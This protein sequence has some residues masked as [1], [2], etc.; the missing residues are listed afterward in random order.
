[1]FIVSIPLGTLPGSYTG[2]VGLGYYAVPGDNVL[3]NSVPFT[4]N[5]AAPTPEPTTMLLLGTGLLGIAAK[6]KRRRKEL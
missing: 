3:T 5:V 6:F 1:M 2:S 4:V